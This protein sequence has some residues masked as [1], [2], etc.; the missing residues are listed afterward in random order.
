MNKR[1]VQPFA[2]VWKIR[3]FK[4]QKEAMGLAGYNKALG[5]GRQ[6][7]EKGRG[8][9][10]MRRHVLTSSLVLVLAA[11]GAGKGPVVPE[12][13]SPASGGTGSGDAQP[14]TG[15]GASTGTAQ[16][17]TAETPADPGA[18]DPRLGGLPLALRNNVITCEATGKFYDIGAQACTDTALAPFPCTVDDNFKAQLDP[19]TLEPFLDYLATKAKDMTIYEC[20]VDDTNVNV[21]FYRNDQTT[22]VYRKLSVAK[23]K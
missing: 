3:L 7:T 4:L 18:S 22:V 17:A 11:C 21:H 8:G 5:C 20:T 12:A 23:K 1:K 6:T 13:S 14:Q 15:A 16:G 19:S 10:F 9:R 2:V